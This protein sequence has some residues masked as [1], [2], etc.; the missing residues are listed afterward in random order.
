MT[1]GDF[2]AQVAKFLTVDNNRG[3]ISDLRENTLRQAVID[4]QSLV[5]QFRLGHE[6]VYTPSDLTEVGYASRGVKPPGSAI[7]KVIIA[8]AYMVVDERRVQRIECRPHDYRNNESMING[9]LP[10][11]G[12]AGFYA[13]DRYGYTFMV[14]PAIKEEMVVSLEW[15]GVK[16]D[17]QD[18]D[19]TPFNE[20]MASVAAKLIKAEIA[21]DVEKD[22]ALHNSFMVSYAKGKQGL[23]LDSREI[24]GGQS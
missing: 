1:W 10:V 23:Y 7:R 18:D 16:L 12:D 14:Y 15:D 6:T 17:F 9:D 24:N 3:G 2:K 19:W 5:P 20:R 13:I 22:I 21:R 4:I 8:R 11:N